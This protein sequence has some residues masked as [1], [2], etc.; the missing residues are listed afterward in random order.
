M[1]TGTFSR[2]LKGWLAGCG[3]ATAVI[4]IAVLGIVAT[5]PGG[6][7]NF[8]DGGVFALLL[9]SL[10]VLVVTCALTGVPAA[11]VIWLTEK[12]RIRSFLFYG[13]AGGAIGILGQTLLFRSFSIFTWLFVVAGFLAG[14]DYWY[15]AGRH[16]GG[17]PGSAVTAAVSRSP[18]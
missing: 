4:Y 9:P 16:A 3:T 5:A 17:E 1:G 10:L 18:G 2:A 13:C 11:L 6:L 14:F 8:A 7:S 12:F 15:V